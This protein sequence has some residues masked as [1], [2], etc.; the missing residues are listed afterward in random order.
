MTA[1]VEAA[2][3]RVAG[4]GTVITAVQPAGGPASIEGYYDEAFAV[5]G[6]IG[7]IQNHPEADAVVIACFD[8]TGLEAARCM[9]GAPV[10]GI[11]EA[12]FHA[13]S[14][15]AERFGVV[16]TLSRS[17]AA[18]THNLHKYGLAS[19]CAGVRASEVPVLALEDEDSDARARISDEIGRALR[20]DRADGIVLGCAG[21]ADLAEAL[22]QEHGVPVIDGVVCAVKF[23][24]SLVVLGLRTAKV[25]AY[26]WPNRK[27]YSGAMAA[28]S[29]PGKG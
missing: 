4:P 27:A 9:T 21:M 18:L 28:Y 29:P 2:A 1:K 3:R 15:V 11:G 20:E 19:R 7:E 6:L 13:A 23:A 8:D 16:T 5:P 12:G 17:V 25:G 24:E 26:A 22:G 14:M 10:I